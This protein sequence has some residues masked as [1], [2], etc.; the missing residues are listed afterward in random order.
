MADT[1]SKR[2]TSVAPDVDP[3]QLASLLARLL[4]GVR[5]LTL[6]TVDP[7]RTVPHVNTCYFAELPD[8]RLT[9]LT[10]PSTRHGIYIGAGAYCAVNIFSTHHHVGDP[11]AG[12]QLAGP[13]RPAEEGEEPAE[14]YEAYVR[15]HPKFRDF[16]PSLGVVH[17]TFESRFYIFEIAEGQLIDEAHLGSERYVRFGV[18]GP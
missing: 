17:E 12:V 4:S 1:G 8:Y 9:V 15:K 6:A 2:L 14:A 13:A 7:D 18:R 16:A 5:L 10:P 11:I 3:D